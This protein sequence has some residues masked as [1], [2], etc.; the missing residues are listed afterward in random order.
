MIAID[1]ELQAQ[2]DAQLLEQGA[3]SPLDLLIET[4]RLAYGDYEAW[5]RR[6]I[7]VLD[8]V[9]MGNPEKI[10]A[11]IEAAAG[12]ARSIR[13]E[14]QT[15]EF[16][17]WHAAGKQDS[18]APLRISADPVLQRLIASRFAPTQNAPQL[19]LF[20]DNPVVALTNGIVRALRARDL[21]EAQRQLDRLYA[22]SPTHADLAAFDRLLAALGHLD[23][24]IEDA[25]WQLD[26]LLETA[27]TAKRL[28]GAQWRDL[29][30]PLWRQLADALDACPFSS[31][32]PDL[33]R[34]F[35]LSQAQDW[36]G[37][38]RCVLAESEWW[39]QPVLC[40]RLAQAA[41]Y[42]KRRIEALTAWCHVCWRAPEQV[43]Q[44][45]E[46]R[47]QPD[48]G[49][50]VLWQQFV[51]LDEEGVRE[52]N[53]PDLIPA[54]PTLTAADFPAWLLLQEPGLAQQLAADLP[55]GN[56]P[57]EEHYRHV[58]RWVQARRAGRGQEEIELRKALQQS[59]AGL[60]RYLKRTV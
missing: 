45:L 31:D 14:E 1:P 12:Y 9:L 27:P 3:F 28:L 47:R 22:Q 48:A 46:G 16:H 23:R 39:V 44:V 43:A 33:H 2:V 5:R 29:L 36:A 58:H 50:A 40:L 30:A 49:M 34:S 59:H 26:F 55:M 42:T 25:P 21:T 6:E 38:S 54:E 51:E 19:D 37:V 57:G 13:L 18:A 24:A 35:A 15:E 8:G 53:G 4:G 11:Y 60:F 20:F 17:A 56:S 41:F 10:R 7:A 52:R 32:T